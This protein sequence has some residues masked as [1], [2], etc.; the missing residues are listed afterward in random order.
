VCIFILWLSTEYSVVR[1]GR[2]WDRITGGGGVRFRTCPN[3]SLELTQ[4]P[5][6][7]YWVSFP[8]VKRPGHGVNHPLFPSSAEV[9]ERVELYLYSPSGSS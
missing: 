6:S 5:Y 3:W 8:G 2:S 9:K 1:V 7:G 4:P